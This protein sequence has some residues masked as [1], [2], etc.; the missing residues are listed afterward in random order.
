MRTITPQLGEIHFFISNSFHEAVQPQFVDDDWYIDGEFTVVDRNSTLFI[1]S[2]P[3]RKR[4]FRKILRGPD[5][6]FMNITG[7]LGHVFPFFMCSPGFAKK[8]KVELYKNNITPILIDEFDRNEAIKIIS[9][10]IESAGKNL[11]VDE[12]WNHLA[13][14]SDT[15]YDS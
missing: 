7:D 11:T 2:L 9:S 15:K 13:T 4:I 3:R 5:G 6:K 12:L 10:K 1:N 14:F 8:N